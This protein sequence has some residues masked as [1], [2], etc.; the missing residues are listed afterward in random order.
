MISHSLKDVYR[1]LSVGPGVPTGDHADI[2]NS[3]VSVLIL[4]RKKILTFL[5]N[6]V[7]TDV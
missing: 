2:L 5:V 7:L 1:V 6:P 4:M 3:D